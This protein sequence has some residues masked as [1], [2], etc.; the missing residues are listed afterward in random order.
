MLEQIPLN[1]LRPGDVANVSQLVGSPDH[2]RRVEELGIRSGAR[3]EIVR[4]G[5]P[6]IL[7]IGGSTFCFRDDQHVRILVSPRKTA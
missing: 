5:S 2:V 6:C 7:R 3:V 1:S 4:G